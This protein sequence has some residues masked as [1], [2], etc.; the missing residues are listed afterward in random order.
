MKISNETKV[1]ALTAIAITLLI[2]G[3][4]FLKGRS[5]FKT[6][7]YIY[8]KFTD[9][10]G[11][12][13]SNSVYVNGFQI[14][15][16]IEIENEDANLNNIIVAIKLNTSYNIPDNSVASIKDNP[17]GSPQIEIKLGTSKIYLKKGA[18]IPSE[19]SL[20]MFSAITNQLTP[21]TDQLKATLKELELTLQNINSIFDP[22]SKSNLQDAIANINKTTLMLAESTTS[23]NRML[24]KQNG[25]IAKTMDNVNSITSNLANQNEKISA[26]LTNIKTTTENLSEADLKGSVASFK[27]SI[28]NLNSVIAKMN[29]TDGSLGLMMND[30]KLYNNLNNSVRSANILLDDLRAHPKRYLNFSVFG[31][32][33]K[34]GYLIAPLDSTKN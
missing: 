9:V 24:E 27:K 6:G 20:G 26:T 10:K 30:K 16:V 23:L 4:S 2:L 33:D 12:Q 11:L 34:G 31:K 17:L 32:K 8:A 18:T 14:G 29:S 15:N 19:N 13:V 7:N 3:Y 21:T 1:G 28:D 22:K 25:S 5:L